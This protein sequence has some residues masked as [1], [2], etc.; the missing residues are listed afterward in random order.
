MNGVDIGLSSF[1]LELDHRRRTTN[2]R[3]RYNMINSNEIFRCH[4]FQPL[5]IALMLPAML[6]V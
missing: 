5:I 4:I 6:E 3:Y 2:K 1:M